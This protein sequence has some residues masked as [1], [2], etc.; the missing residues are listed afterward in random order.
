M[1]FL[2]CILLSLTLYSLTFAQTNTGALGTPDTNLYYMDEVDVAPQFPG[3]M[4]SLLAFFRNNIVVP[5]KAKESNNQG[6]VYISFVI[7]ET[8]AVSNIDAIRRI[9]AGCDE[10]AMRVAALMPL[11]TPGMKNEK[12]VKTKLVLPVHF[13]GHD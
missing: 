12:P 2:W 7:T 13:M 6:T 11:W 8:G 3:G 10:E 1:R 9:G 4:D 5:S